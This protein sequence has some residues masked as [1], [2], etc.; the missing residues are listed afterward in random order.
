VY[1]QCVLYLSG[2]YCTSGV[3][4]PMPGASNDTTG[5]NCSCPTQAFH[6]GV[7]GICPLGHYC[8]TGSD[9]PTPCAAGSYADQEGLSACLTCPEGYYCLA[10]AQGFTN[11]TCPVGQCHLHFLLNFLVTS[12]T[13]SCHENS[14]SLYI[15]LK[16]SVLRKMRLT[17]SMIVVSPQATTV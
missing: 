17:Q 8:P 5:V 16:L 13:A 6:T 3:D 2:Y 7:G 9:L 4:R 11:A 1:W 14:Y 12:F 15:F 10:G